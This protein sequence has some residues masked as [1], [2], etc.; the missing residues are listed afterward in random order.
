MAD[1]QGI[2]ILPSLLRGIMAQAGG[3]KDFPWAD[4]VI[5]APFSSPLTY[6]NFVL[7]CSFKKH[8]LIVFM[9]RYTS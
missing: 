9:V 6:S 7:I 1:L 4:E 2:R 8:L 5:S 3:S